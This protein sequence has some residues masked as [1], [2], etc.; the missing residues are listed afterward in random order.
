MEDIVKIAILM[1]R[2]AFAPYSNYRVGAAVKTKTGEIIGGCN[3]ESSS[4]GLTCCAERVAIYN[5]ISKGFNQFNSIAVSTK[6]PAAGR[7]FYSIPSYTFWA[8][9]IKSGLKPLGTSGV[10]SKTGIFSAFMVIPVAL[11]MR[12]T[13]CDGRAK[14]SS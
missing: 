10:F 13:I 4:Y 8:M 7:V 14:N 6:N 11:A 3:I 1:R 12:S 5:A 9:R 2:R